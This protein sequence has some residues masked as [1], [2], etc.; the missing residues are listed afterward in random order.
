MSQ[1]LRNH[2][3]TESGTGFVLALLVTV[4]TVLM[5][6]LVIIPSLILGQYSNESCG[7]LLYM[8]CT[9]FDNST[10]LHVIGKNSVY[11]IRPQL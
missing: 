11:I 3:G 9:V 7:S 1:E 6:K 5:L 8:L 4:L 10:T 2:A